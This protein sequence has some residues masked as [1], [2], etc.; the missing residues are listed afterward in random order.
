MLVVYNVSLYPLEAIDF[1]LAMLERVPERLFWVEPVAT[2]HPDLP[3]WVHRSRVV[4]RLKFCYEIETSVRS[5]PL[6][7]KLE[8]YP[9]YLLQSSAILNCWSRLLETRVTANMF[10]CNECSLL[11]LI[12]AGGTE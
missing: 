12:D 8:Q 2:C 11:F 10:K 6:S 4:S 7:V 3:T 1:F 9:T 5:H